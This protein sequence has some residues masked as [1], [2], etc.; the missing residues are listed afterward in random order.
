MRS[1]LGEL[2]YHR[3]ALAERQIKESFTAFPG[4]RTLT[5]RINKLT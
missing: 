2:A 3:P 1:S 5:V 4:F